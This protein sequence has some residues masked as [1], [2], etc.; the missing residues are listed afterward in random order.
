MPSAPA[1]AAPSF[2]QSGLCRSDLN[3]GLLNQSGNVHPFGYRRKVRKHLC[4][5]SEAP[6]K[7]AVCAC[8]SV[9]CSLSWSR[10]LRKSSHSMTNRRTRSRNHSNILFRFSNTRG[11]CTST[12]GCCGANTSWWALSGGA[13]TPPTNT[14]EILRC[15][16]PATKA[17][18]SGWRQF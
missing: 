13:G 16:R 10:S 7:C 8:A 1:I 3:T 15:I 6:Q 12:G 4:R 5:R 2:R 17:G 9:S 18:N 11:F 14:E